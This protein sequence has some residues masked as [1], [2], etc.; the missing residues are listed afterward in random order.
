MRVTLLGSSGF[1]GSSLAAHCHARGI[2][3]QVVSRSMPAN[4]EDLGHVIDCVG[5]TADFRTRLLDTV[6]AHVSFVADFFRKSRFQSFLYLS[7]TRVYR[8][9]ASTKEEAAICVDPS[10]R[11]DLYDISK[12]MGESLCLSQDSPTIRVARLSNVYGSDY[13]SNNFLPSIIKDALQRGEVHIASGKLGE[14]D[15]VFIDDVC[16]LLLAISTRG[17]CR[18]YNVASGYNLTNEAVG[19]F[20]EAETGC[21]VSYADDV[22]PRKFPEIDIQRIKTEFDFRPARFSDRFSEVMQS[23][24]KALI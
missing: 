7:S 18:V 16:M 5:M 3:F 6:D 20:M 23:Y 2:E 17:K 1:I 24:R 12:L 21:R 14:K 9:A 10:Q 13:H 8:R 11:D 4:H 22:M 15:Y 19:R